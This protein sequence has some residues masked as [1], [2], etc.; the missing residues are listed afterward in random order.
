MTAIPEPFA[1]LNSNS[2]FNRMVGPFYACLRDEQIVIGVRLDDQHCN[3]SG[4]L[5]GAMVCAIF[6]AVLGHN[7]GL[8]LLKDN[9]E[10]ITPYATGVPGGPLVT[11]SLSTDYMGTAQ[12]G[13]WLE[14]TATTQ[15]AGKSS[16]FGNA[17]LFAQ[18]KRIAKASGIFRVFT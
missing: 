9:G 6:D 1:P 13:E 4:R 7:V 14:A 12:V 10:D 15:S 2:P 5:H 11:T 8:Q 18:N 3:N 16:V 17:E